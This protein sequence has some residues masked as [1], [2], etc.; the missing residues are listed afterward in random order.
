VLLWNLLLLICCF[1]ILRN[2]KEQSLHEQNIHENVKENDK[3]NIVKIEEEK[4]NHTVNVKQDVSIDAEIVYADTVKHDRTD[5]MVESNPVSPGSPSLETP[6]PTDIN[7][8]KIKHVQAAFE[9]Y[10]HAT[11]E[12]KEII[13]DTNMKE[14]NNSHHIKVNKQTTKRSTDTQLESLWD[15]NEKE[16]KEKNETMNHMNDENKN[17][18]VITV[19]VHKQDIDTNKKNKK[20]D[21]PLTENDEPILELNNSATPI[22]A[23]KSDE[24][25][26][27]EQKYDDEDKSYLSIEFDPSVTLGSRATPIN[28]YTPNQTMGINLLEVDEFANQE[29]EDTAVESTDSYDMCT[30]VEEDDDGATF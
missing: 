22:S 29:P 2:R 18:I 4:V 7:N 3:K 27:S 15:E 6:M 16:H 1:Y 28:N 13:D 26:I 8:L 23:Q 25:P 21:T 5:F 10:N 24:T 30:P 11:T 20:L 17:N 14:T 12:I 9:P 19:D